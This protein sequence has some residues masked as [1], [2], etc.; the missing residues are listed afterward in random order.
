M[1]VLMIQRAESAVIAVTLV[2]LLGACGTLKTTRQPT[3]GALQTVPGRPPSSRNIAP[4]STRSAD[5]TASVSR[6]PGV[7]LIKRLDPKGCVVIYASGAVVSADGKVATCRH[8]IYDNP[9]STLV[10]CTEDGIDHRVLGVLVI[11]A[12]VDLVLLQLEPGDYTPVPLTFG[13]S[14][15]APQP[16]RVV[17]Y[18]HGAVQETATGLVRE[19]VD[20]SGLLDDFVQLRLSVPVVRGSSGAPVFDQHGQVLALIAG[21]RKDGGAASVA[22]SIAP[23]ARWLS[24]PPR[25]PWPIAEAVP[26]ID[27]DFALLQSEELRVWEKAD[28]QARRG[29]AR[30]CLER[31]V[32]RYS[33]SSGALTMLAWELVLQKDL[34]GAERRARAATAINSDS[35]A[36]WHVLGVALQAQGRVLE[37]EVCAR[38]AVALKPDL[39]PRFQAP[40]VDRQP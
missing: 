37:A 4:E 20:M 2:L 9:S 39:K 32:D 29:E 13:I 33:R 12:T 10:A 36:A 15:P 31:L 19:V 23:V 3:D 40:V 16:V 14:G 18:P 30:A 5:P 7:V 8:V 1:K 27:D 35:S 22:W 28:K 24:Q 6:E 11:H 21:F 17:G 26:V 25:K 38:R 34:V